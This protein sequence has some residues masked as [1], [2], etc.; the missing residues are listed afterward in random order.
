MENIFIQ[1][2]AYRDP[3]LLP[4]LRDCISKAYFPQNLIFSIS[5]QH[6]DSDEW[7]NLYEYL[8]DDRFKI[9]DIPYKESKGACWARNLLQHQYNGETYTL[10]LDSHHRFIENWDRELIIM[11]KQLQLKGYKKPLL[12]AYAPFYDNATEEIGD[13][14][15]PLI[16]GFEKFTSEGAVLFNYYYLHDEN[17]LNDPIPA[18]FYSA[19]FCFTLGQFCNEVRHDP[20]YYFHGE[21][22]S[23]AV[24]A[25]TS[26]YDLF[27]P[28]KNV[29]FH[30]Y[31]RDQRR[32]HWDD[33]P[34]WWQLDDSS[35]QRNRILFGMEPGNIDFGKY[36]FG[37]CRSLKDYEL[38]SGINFKERK[39]KNV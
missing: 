25:Y 36:G 2:A 19:H 35:L 27:H 39:Y 38:Y 17:S 4:T 7:D 3:E 32:T 23:I 5:W 26:G 34:D 8:D 21:E 14:T 28:H 12:T 6:C 1:I 16:M 15:Q 33:D 22:I 11:L 37:T 9:I 10:Q 30:F 29:L 31:S 20:N 24:R 13:P 18:K